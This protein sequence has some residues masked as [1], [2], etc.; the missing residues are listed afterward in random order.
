MT[1]PNNLEGTRTP[2]EIAENFRELN[3]I[4]PTP[5]EK[6]RLM[7]GHTNESMNDLPANLPPLP[8]V[9]PGF[10]R[11]EY[12]GNN[13]ATTGE[14]PCDYSGIGSK[15]WNRHHHG[16]ALCVSIIE[17]QADYVIE[18][19]REPAKDQP[20]S[21]TAA[22][23]AMNGWLLPTGVEARVCESPTPS[24]YRWTHE[25]VTFDFYRLCEILGITSHA[26][27]HALK[28]VIR[29]G[30]GGKTLLQDI[31]EAIDAMRRFREMVEEV[32]PQPPEGGPEKQ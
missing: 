24:R 10:D 32:Q 14:H 30:R 27:A 23:A 15:Q 13:V 31:D 8:P 25:G 18:A 29:A 20:A 17:R 6:F 12:R 22:I 26:Q 21:G 28:K 2:E 3:R 16:F 1:D 5:A 9:P 11:W 19:V 4:A 7:F